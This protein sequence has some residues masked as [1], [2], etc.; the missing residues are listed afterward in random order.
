MKSCNLWLACMLIGLSGCLQGSVAAAEII[1]IR[2]SFMDYSKDPFFFDESESVRFLADGL[3]LIE[4]GI[5]KDF[6]HYRDLVGK[7]PEAKITHYQDRL[8]MPGFIDTHVHY[9]QS[10]VTG[11][12]GKHKPEWLHGYIFPEEVRCRDEEYARSVAAFFLDEML[13]CGT[14]TV[15][16]FTTPF[17]GS[18]D[19][20]FEEASKRNMRVISGLTGV[21]RKGEG[22]PGYATTPGA[23]YQQSKKLY[24]KWH[25]KGRNLYAVTPRYAPGCTDELLAKAGQ[26]YKELPGVYMNTH[27]SEPKAIGEN[28][29]PIWGGEDW[30]TCKRLF[31]EASDYLN[32]FER[33][34]LLGPRTTYGHGIWLSDSE[35]ER[36]SKTGTSVSFCPA[37]NLFLGSGLFRISQAKSKTLPVRMSLGTDMAGGNYFCQIKVLNDAYKVA[38][39]Q[40]YSLSAIKGFYLATKGGAHALYL[41]DKIGGFK[42]GLEADFIVL[43]LVATPE[44]EAR[45]KNG[46][47]SDLKELE[48]K[49]FGLMVLGDERAVSATYIA[50]KP[51]TKK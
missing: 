25:G 17:P 14:T 43:N 3:L 36:M 10:R 42:P 29:K 39:L 46:K 5:I 35:F 8:I 48:D 40:D 49:I 1:G 13:R 24:E 26:L 41:D 2:S 12:F 37:S 4:G 31:P 32:I 16:S 47:V 15:Q 27:I 33:H 20:F 11:A 28:G 45:N 19:V 44:L 23:F 51:M 50:G 21:D 6:G 30:L 18:V 22:P 34:G 38:I 7:Y 9:V